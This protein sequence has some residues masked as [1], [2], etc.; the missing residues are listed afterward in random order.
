MKLKGQINQRDNGQI[1]YVVH[2]SR[3]VGGN[4]LICMSLLSLVT[5]EE[6]KH[7]AVYII[8]FVKFPSLNSG[9]RFQSNVLLKAQ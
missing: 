7:Q 1:F 6:G 9:N 4:W 3:V 5:A 8:I 2:I